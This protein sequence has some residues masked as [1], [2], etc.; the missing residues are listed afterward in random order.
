MNASCFIPFI[1][2]FDENLIPKNFVSPYCDIHPIAK[3]ATNDLKNKIS[4][5]IKIDLKFKNEY[6]KTTLNRGKMF[7]V[8]VVKNPEGKLGYLGGFSG[9]IGNSSHF[10]YFVPPVVDILE[11]NISID[12]IMSEISILTK[13]INILKAEDK[14][15]SKLKTSIAL[16]KNK[17]I[18]LQQNIFNEY[19]FLNSKRDKKSLKSIFLDFNRD[20]IPA[21]AGECAAPILFQYAFK[22]NLTPIALAEFWWG[23]SPKSEIK[24]HGEFYPPCIAKC[25]PILD[26]MLNDLM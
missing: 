26:F 9:K 14:S 25:E 2:S 19:N 10:D 22:N 17:S 15:H 1:S 8:L 3:L 16:R 4:Q 6:L 23:I 13:E 12:S 7:G 24:K 5:L 18:A 21:G 20:K 11:E